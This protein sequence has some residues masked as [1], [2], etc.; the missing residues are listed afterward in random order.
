MMWMAFILT[1]SGYFLSNSG[2]DSVALAQ[3]LAETGFSYTPSSPGALNAVYKA[4]R[5]D[6]ISQLVHNVHSQTMLEKPWVEVSRF[7]G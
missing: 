3:F 4:W 5:R 2:Y 7:P 6:K 1:I